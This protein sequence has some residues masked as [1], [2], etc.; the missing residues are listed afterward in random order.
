MV[1]MFKFYF[2]LL[3][4]FSWIKNMKCKRVRDDDDG[5]EDQGGKIF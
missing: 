1:N 5:D 4:I 3:Y 2:C